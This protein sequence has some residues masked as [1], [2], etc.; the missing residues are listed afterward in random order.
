MLDFNDKF[1]EIMGSSREKLLGFNSARQSSPLVQKTIKR[2][3]AGQK[4]SFEE[5]YTSVTGGKTAYI[6]GVFNPVSPG[7]CPTDLIATIEDITEQKLHE[8]EQHKIEKIESLGILAGGIAHDFNNILSGIM[9]NVSF[10]QVLV[11]PKHAAY[12]HLQQAEKASKRAAELSTRLLTFAK[13]GE[14]NK[15]VVSLQQLIQETGCLML[16]GS[17]VRLVLNSPDKVQ[18]IKADEGQISQVLTNMIINA[19]QAMPDGGTLNITTTNIILPESNPFGLSTGAYVKMTLKDEGCGISPEHTVKIFDPYFTTKKA[20]TGLGLASAYS[21]I[22]RHDGHITVDSV[23]GKG[24]VFTIYLPVIDSP[25][26]DH[27]IGTAPRKIFHHVGNILV[28]DDEEMILDVAKTILVHLGY[29]AA[30]STNGEE[31]IELYKASVKSGTPFKA[32]IMDLTI[33]GGLGGKQVAERILNLYPLACL[34]VS[35]GYSNDPIMANYKEYGF[36]AAITKPYSMKDFEQVLG[37][38]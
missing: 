4:A 8:K 38:L 24:T 26:T 20:G 3:L 37:S 17:N 27:L 15:K 9:A 11:D 1:I 14:P 34:I 13:G 18:A 10:A 2:A 7:Q 32:V 29:N 25:S 6:R 35:S 5:C 23:V 36:S 21:I 12:K 28:M 16:I 30:T 22:H 31:T 19:T 33:P